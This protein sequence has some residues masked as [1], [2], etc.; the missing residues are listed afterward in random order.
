MTFLNTKDSKIEFIEYKMSSTQSITGGDQIIKLDSTTKRTTGGDAVSYN[1]TTGVLT[2]SSSRR[3]WVQASIFY[4]RNSNAGYSIEWVTDSSMSEVTQTSGGFR[5]IVQVTANVSGY[6]RT[7][8]HT[9]H[10]L[11]DNPTNAY[12]LNYGNG[13]SG[14]ILTQTNMFIIEARD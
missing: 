3:Y 10:L 5:A 1:S 2:L 7:S 6:Y 4:D 8:N 14:D 13:P 12:R 11:V 9:A